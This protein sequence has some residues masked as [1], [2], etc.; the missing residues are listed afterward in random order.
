MTLHE[1]R[2]T[3]LSPDLGSGEGSPEDPDRDVLWV[4]LPFVFLRLGPNPV[5]SVTMGK[6]DG[7]GG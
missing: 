7:V 6:V 4:C 5:H 3:S 1:R 2:R